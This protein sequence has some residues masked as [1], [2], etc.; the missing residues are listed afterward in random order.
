MPSAPASAPASLPGATGTH[1]T[2]RLKLVQMG[3]PPEQS[4][5]ATHCTQ[6]ALTVSQTVAPIIVHWAL[7]VQPARHMNVRWSQTG[8]AVP[9]SE[10]VR[11]GTHVWVDT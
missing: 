4:E 10:F 8:A 11:Q 1:C 7:L 9:Q 5:L 3:V 6:R 2:Q